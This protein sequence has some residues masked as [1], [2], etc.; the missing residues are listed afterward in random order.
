MTKYKTKAVM[1]DQFEQHF[2]API[3]NE[4]HTGEMLKCN[5]LPM[6]D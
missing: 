2:E 4:S 6:Y 5:M 3:H 1:A